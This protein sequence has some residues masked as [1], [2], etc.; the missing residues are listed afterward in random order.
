MRGVAKGGGAMACLGYMLP[1]EDKVFPF[2]FGNPRRD[3]TAC[4]PLVSEF[5]L[6]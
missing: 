1:L 6:S 3:F 2:K 5:W 4:S